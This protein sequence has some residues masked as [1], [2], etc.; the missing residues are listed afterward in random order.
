M[1]VGLTSLALALAL[2]WG[3]PSNDTAHATAAGSRPIPRIHRALVVSVDGLRPDLVLRADAPM[4][5]GLL[6][7]GS[8]TLWARTTSLAVTLPSHVSMLTGVPP[9]QHRIVW[10]EDLPLSRPVYPA[11][12]TLFE[13]A[14]AAGYT[15]AMI[16]GKAKFA[17]LDKPG[18]LDWSFVPD[19][20]V[21]DAMVAD[22]A[23]LVVERHRPRVMFVHLPGVDTAGHE[24]GWGSKEQLAAVTAADRALGRVMAAFGRATLD[25]TIVIVSADHGGAGTSH[26]PDDP[27]SLMIP[28]IAVGPGIRQ[29]FD[30]SSVPNLDVRTEDTFATVCWL[31]ALTPPPPVVGRPV[32]AMLEPATVA[33]GA[34]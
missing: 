24:H 10:N 23:V 32:E 1:N 5:R 28:W 33:H 18:T 12:S 26:G 9:N 19:S 11:R 34:R 8:F 7:H 6:A 16:A 14:H 13:V 4:L 31:L 22:Q 25:S 30:L 21:S 17:A 27:R 3:G 15:T 29:N 20:T 2:A